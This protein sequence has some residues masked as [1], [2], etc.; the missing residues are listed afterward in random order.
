[1][2]SFRF[3]NSGWEWRF[4]DDAD[5]VSWVTERC[6]EMLPAYRA[7]STGIHRA[8]FFRILVLYFDGGV[9]ADID[10]E[11]LRPLDELTARL[12]ADK[13]VYLTRDHPIHERIHFGGRAMWMNDFMLAEPGDPFLGEVMHW[14]LNSPPSSA[15]S[16]NAVMETGPGVLSS[17][18]EMLG[19]TEQVPSL[20]VMPTPWVHPLPDMN[21]GFPEKHYYG[22]AIA[23][24]AWL[25][26]EVFVVHYWFHTWVDVQ[27]NTL[28][29]YADVLLSTRGEQVERKLQWHLG[30]EPSE[31]DGV[32]ACALA[33]FAEKQG[34]VV[35]HVQQGED[36]FIDRFLELLQVAGLR[37]RLQISVSATA[38][39]VDQ[40]VAAL[41]AIA[42]TYSPTSTWAASGSTLLVRSPDETLGCSDLILDFDGL[43]LGPKVCAGQVVVQGEGACLTEVWPVAHIVPRVVHL[44]PSDLPYATA[45]SGHFADCG[46]SAQQWSKL[47]IDQWLA[48]ASMGTWNLEL[49]SDRD[50]EVAFALEILY[51]QGGG[52]F[53]GDS[54][55]AADEMSHSWTQTLVHGNAFWLFACPPRCHLLQGALKHWVDA[56]R[57][58]RAERPKEAAKKR[59]LTEHMSRDVTLPEFLEIRM[60]AMHLTGQASNLNA[61]RVSSPLSRMAKKLSPF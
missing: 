45:I 43:V 27:M 4:Y 37:P 10:V 2:E 44:F 54:I 17:V 50:K 1:M 9:Y 53:V 61:T 8:D 47:E 15:A 31:V 19:G 52:V 22:Q 32:L 55:A 49:L 36:V 3:M 28:T 56:R 34:A 38:V 23:T 30:A 60:R 59:E 18:V 5:C 40:R 35:L 6:P 33:E 46:I 12:P 58:S 24:R 48:E 16:S 51:A 11:C 42:R 25:E 26:R 41:E 7:Y 57:R 13:S 20:G 29:D 39:G 14:M 21:C